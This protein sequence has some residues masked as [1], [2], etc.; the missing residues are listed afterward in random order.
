MQAEPQERM[1]GATIEVTDSGQILPLPEP[2]QRSLTLP[3]WVQAVG[4][5]RKA[6]AGVIILL[7][8]AL[9]ALLAPVIA[10]GDSSD[11]VDRPHRPP[12]AEHLLGTTGQG[13][14]VFAQTVWGARSTL[15]VGLIVGVL[16]TVVGIV[17]GL[18]AG[19]FGGAV[20]D[21]L[22]LM[23]NVFLIVPS[24]PL[25][26]VLAMTVVMKFANVLG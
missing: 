7:I 14:D 25:L 11:F 26:V 16:T 2:G 6:V 8:F 21:V 18:S 20:D 10:P 19:Y 5:S 1:S 13:Q 3:N 15:S 4:R 9:V 17:V 12:S 24:L 22:S 23:T